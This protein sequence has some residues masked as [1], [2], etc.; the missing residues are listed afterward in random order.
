ML[1]IIAI[2][3][4][5]IT[6]W[7]LS[8]RPEFSSISEITQDA[9]YARFLLRKSWKLYLKRNLITYIILRD[10]KHIENSY[11]S[12]VFKSVNKNSTDVAAAVTTMLVFLFQV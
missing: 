7:K 5:M 8:F 9:A 11:R 1:T 12:K 2:I 3:I 4:T 10:L 6:V